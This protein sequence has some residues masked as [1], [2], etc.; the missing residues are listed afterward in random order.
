MKYFLAC[1]RYKIC[2]FYCDQNNGEEMGP[3]FQVRIQ[4]PRGTQLLRLKIANIV[5]QSC[6]S[7]VSYLLLGSRA[8][9]RAME[10]FGFLMLKYA[11]SD[12]LETFSLIL[13]STSIPK[14]DKNSTLHCIQSILN[15]FIY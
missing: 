3:L 6:V 2:S 14:A 10:A 11:F 9:L 5:K 4:Y 12:I 8:H 1:V 15:I 13:T 7:E